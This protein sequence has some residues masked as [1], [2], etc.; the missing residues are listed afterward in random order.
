MLRGHVSG[1]VIQVTWFHYLELVQVK[2]KKK[3]IAL[4][5]DYA[6]EA[7]EAVVPYMMPS[8]TLS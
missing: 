8:P 5:E 1:C 6:L 4:Q 7:I 2:P 3:I